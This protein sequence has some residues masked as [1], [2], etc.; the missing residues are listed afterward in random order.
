MAVGR[1]PTLGAAL[2]AA[3]R[4]AGW[5]TGRELKGWHA[6]LSKL[7]ETPRGQ[8][9]LLAAGLNPGRHAINWRDWLSKDRTPTKEN[10]A[11]IAEAYA[12]YRLPKWIRT[13]TA[14]ITG[15]IGTEGGTTRNRGTDEA[16]LKIDHRGMDSPSQHAARWKR[17]EDAWA[18]GADEAD[19]EDLY[20]GDV[21]EADLDMSV[22]ETGSGGYSVVIA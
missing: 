17:I 22:F 5:H 8:E 16:A 20:V 13:A 18:A 2:I 12:A 21:V 3:F 15:A 4:A 11:K 19:F 7:T 10:Q 1:G 14:S 6:R 9:T